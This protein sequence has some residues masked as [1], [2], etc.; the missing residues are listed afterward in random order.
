MGRKLGPRLCRGQYELRA[1]AADRCAAE[2]K[3]AAVEGREIRD[4]RKAEPRARLVLV[5]LAATARNLLARF[6]RQARPVIVDEDM[7]EGAVDGMAG[8]LPE[9]LDF[10][11]RVRPFAGVVDE[12]AEHLLE[13]L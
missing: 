9:H 5:E 7:E 3:L 1:Q 2:H 13:I 6:R 4:D 10:D 11:A 8:F 12:I